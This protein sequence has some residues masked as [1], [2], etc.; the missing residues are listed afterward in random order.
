VWSGA[1]LWI[2]GGES[3]DGT[4]YNNG[5]LYFPALGV[6]GEWQP[7]TAEGAPSARAR[8]TAVLSTVGPSRVLVWGGDGGHDN[9]T[10]GAEELAV[11]GDGAIFDLGDRTW[12][13]LP[14]AP[15]EAR[16]LHVA[17]MAR[18]EM[19][20]WGGRNAAGAVLADGAAYGV[21]TGRWVVLPDRGERPSGRIRHRAVW[22]G[23]QFIVWGGVG[24]SG[25]PLGDGARLTY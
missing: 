23:G 6:A 5:A 3:A 18:D 25:E 2:W 12:R 11:H 24:A 8:A 10:Y 4:T 7:T 15:I 21:T 22:T 13:A 16:T 17:V 1:A 19:L 9:G 20:V 14:R